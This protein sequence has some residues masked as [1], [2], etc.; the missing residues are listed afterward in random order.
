MR[1]QIGLI[2]AVGF[3][4]LFAAANAQAPSSSTAGTTFDGTYRFVSSTKVNE[5]YTSY[6][7]QTVQ[8]P[9]RRA[10]PLHIVDGRV[11]YATSTGYR[12]AG[13]VGPQGELTMRS[14]TMVASSRPFRIQASGS[15]DGSRTA[16]VRQRASA[17][18]Y[19]FVW[20]RQQ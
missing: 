20:Q 17:C 6:N 7:G 8:C 2:S 16:H 5:M 1:K 3:S 9:N 15:I 4:G 12:L 18:N 19:D 10:G 13:M 11:H 14:I